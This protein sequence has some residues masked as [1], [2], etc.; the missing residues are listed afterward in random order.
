MG[1]GEVRIASSSSSNSL[2]FTSVSFPISIAQLN[3]SPLRPC[4]VLLAAVDNRCCCDYPVVWSV[5]VRPA[6]MRTSVRSSHPW[7]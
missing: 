5:A 1:R 6:F 4:A 3:A 7:K 2:A